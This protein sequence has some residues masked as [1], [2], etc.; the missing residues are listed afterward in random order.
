MLQLNTGQ[1]IAPIKDKNRGK[2]KSDV[3]MTMKEK[4]LLCE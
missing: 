4:R 3:P 1:P 2:T